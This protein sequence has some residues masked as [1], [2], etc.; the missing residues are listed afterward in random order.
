[1]QISFFMQ[2]SKKD[3]GKIIHVS[4]AVDVKMKLIE[5]DNPLLAEEGIAATSKN[6]G[7]ALLERSIF[8]VF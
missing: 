7:A 6:M 2:R 4:R 5:D 1:M 3:G 8:A